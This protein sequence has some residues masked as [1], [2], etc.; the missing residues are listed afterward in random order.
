MVFYIKCCNVDMEWI[1]QI[2]TIRV[3]N[4]HRWRGDKLCVIDCLL[5]FQMRPL[6]SFIRFRK[7]PFAPY[8]RTPMTVFFYVLPEL[9]GYGL[10]MR[11]IISD[12]TTGNITDFGCATDTDRQAIQQPLCRHMKLKT[13]NRRTEYENL[14]LPGR[15][16][17]KQLI[18]LRDVV[19]FATRKLH[20]M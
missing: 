15:M 9:Y 4:Y 18:G 8:V 12:Q 2:F 17:T 20:G 5:L 13:G 11:P 7:M 16:Q 14:D 1:L 19:E 10:L 6:W 3:T